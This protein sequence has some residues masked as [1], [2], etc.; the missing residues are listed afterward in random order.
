[1]GSLLF[2][3]FCGVPFGLGL[4][5]LLLLGG[6]PFVVGRSQ[7]AVVSMAAVN[8]FGGVWG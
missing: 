3:G 4:S 1:M 8:P 2:S 6:V 7:L 5:L